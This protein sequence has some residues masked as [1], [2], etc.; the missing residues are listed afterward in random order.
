[1]PTQSKGQKS[2]L[3][4][5]WIDRVRRRVEEHADQGVVLG[6]RWIFGPEN[7]PTFDGSP[8]L[9]LITV[10][11][12]TLRWLKLMLLTLSGQKALGL[13]TDIVVVDNASRDGSLGFLRQLAARV[14]RIRLIENRYFLS[15]ARGMRLG[16][17]ALRRS[18][19]TSNVVLSIDTDVIFLRKDV[20]EALAREFENGAALAGEMRHGLYDVPEA[21]ASFV[22][23]RRDVMARRDVLP[24]VNH[25]APSYW[26]QKS[27]RKAGL[28]ISD[29]RSNEGGYAL[30]R[31]RAG[32]AAAKIFRPS[33]SYGSIPNDE[34]HF[35]GIPRGAEIWREVEDNW[36][37]WLAPDTEGECI[38]YLA[39]RFAALHRLTTLHQTNPFT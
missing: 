13:L 30:H 2:Q 33:G 27:I 35:M 21:Q 39:R 17:K 22:A 19:S 37:K 18:S 16:F 1:M 12:S 7:A 10:N 9:A 28:P 31:G 11:F 3:L 4:R 25:G 14:P 6:H 15:H 26:M 32:V 29:F 8:R 20:L 24:W 23:A 34:P 36:A 38:D 5:L